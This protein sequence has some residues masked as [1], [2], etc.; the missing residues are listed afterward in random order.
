LLHET[1]FH[2]GSTVL[3]TWVTCLKVGIYPDTNGT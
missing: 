3:G 1:A 2:N